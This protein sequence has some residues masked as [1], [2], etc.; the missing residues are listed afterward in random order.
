M[1]F[2]AYE[3]SISLSFRDVPFMRI[4]IVSSFQ[5][6]HMTWPKQN[7][8]IHCFWLTEIFVHIVAH[9]ERN[10]WPPTNAKWYAHRRLFYHYNFERPIWNMLQLHSYGHGPNHH[11]SNMN[12]IINKPGTQSVRTSE[13]LHV[14]HFDSWSSIDSHR[15]LLISFSKIITILDFY[16][17]TTSI[18]FYLYTINF[19]TQEM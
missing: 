7:I 17:H 16:S 10:L 14:S 19:T 3:I 12:P 4:C 13:I 1:S 5:F 2:Q 6:A 11:P 18:D 15:F 8:F 9:L